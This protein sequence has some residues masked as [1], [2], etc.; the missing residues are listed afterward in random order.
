VANSK[1]AALAILQWVFSNPREGNDFSITSE[2]ATP[3]EGH[4]FSRVVGIRTFAA[5][6]TQPAITQLCFR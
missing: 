6:P 3:V 4:D 5:S 1:T 2:G